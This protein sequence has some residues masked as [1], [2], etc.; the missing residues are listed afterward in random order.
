M[1]ELVQLLLG[2]SHRVESDGDVQHQRR[3][4]RGEW[5]RALAFLGLRDAQLGPDLDGFGGAL[6]LAR[7][8]TACSGRCDHLAGRYE[9]GAIEAAV[10]MGCIEIDD[11]TQQHLA[12]V[13]GVAP[14]EHG[15]ERQRA[16]ADGTEHRLAAGLDALRNRHLS[17]TRQELDRP[18]LPQIHPNRVVGTPD[19]VMIE[20]TACLGRLA[21]GCRRLFA[22]VALGHRDP[23]FG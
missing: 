17:F 8:H 7:R 3:L 1:P 20:V 4:H 21:F 18:H 10:A 23:E 13:E 19:I 5:D 12:L 9:H 6:I 16:F 2:L 14:T 11:I 15:V 22:L